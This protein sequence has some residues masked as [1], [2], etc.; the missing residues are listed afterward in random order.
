MRDEGS[1]SGTA[2]Q[3]ALY[4]ALARILYGVLARIEEP[5][6]ELPEVRRGPG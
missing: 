3:A 1:A 5:G 6:L 2:D 4:S